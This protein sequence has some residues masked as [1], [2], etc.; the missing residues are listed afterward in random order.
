MDP[1]ARAACKRPHPRP[2]GGLSTV[3]PFAERRHVFQFPVCLSDTP[4]LVN[5]NAPKPAPAVTV[6]GAPRQFSTTMRLE[7]VGEEWDGRIKP[8]TLSGF[9]P[10]AKPNAKPVEIEFTGPDPKLVAADLAERLRPVFADLTDRLR[11]DIAEH[12]RA[13]MAAATRARDAVPPAEPEAGTFPAD[14]LPRSPTW[15]ELRRQ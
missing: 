3:G 13:V 9:V 15:P 8:L 12:S 2:A 14:Y 1:A 10:A 11:A 5:L 7:A 6:A 4:E